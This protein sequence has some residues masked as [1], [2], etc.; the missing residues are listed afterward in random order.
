MKY[1]LLVAIVIVALILIALYLLGLLFTSASPTP[2]FVTLSTPCVETRP[3]LC[4]DW[5]PE[6]DVAQSEPMPTEQHDLCP[7]DGEAA[8]QPIFIKDV[9]TMP[10]G[11][12]VRPGNLINEQGEIFSIIVSA[13]DEASV[14]EY[15]DNVRMCADVVFS[16]AISPAEKETLPDVSM[17]S[18]DALLAQP[19]SLL[20]EIDYVAQ[21]G[22][23][24]QEVERVLADAAAENTLFNAPLPSTGFQTPTDPLIA[25][26]ELIGPDDM[27]QEYQSDH[28]IDFIIDPR[29]NRGVFHNY[30]SK[31]RKSARASV[32]VAGASGAGSVSALLYRNGRPVRSGIL[33]KNGGSTSVSLRYSSAPRHST[34]DAG[35]YGRRNGSRYRI[36]G[37]WVKSYNATRPAGG[38][39][40]CP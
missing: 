19:G 28:A 18:V 3:E 38:G 31:C 32:S 11:R 33:D 26:L 39:S 14:R 10:D 15:T 13:A 24:P 23:S 25:Q 12:S 16:D 37:T 29:I 34:Y 1:P 2:E 20:I 22:V 7:P 21:S 8:Q 35:V 40:V 9:L 36:S 30:R 27:V 6:P 17:E 5:T 4:P